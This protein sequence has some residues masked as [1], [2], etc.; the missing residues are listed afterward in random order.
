MIIFPDIA[1]RAVASRWQYR[2][3]FKEYSDDKKR[4]EWRGVRPLL[5][6]C[7]SRRLVR[8]HLATL[9][10]YISLPCSRTS[11]CLVRV[12]LAALFM[13]ICRL[14]RVHLVKTRQRAIDF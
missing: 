14:V 7:T 11:R 4:N 9:F 12:H 8:V 6:S 2:V 1:C 10:V 3:L 5:A 13:Y